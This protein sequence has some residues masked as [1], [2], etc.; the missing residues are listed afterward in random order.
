[1]TKH[2]IETYAAITEIERNERIFREKE[3]ADHK[4]AT[5]K[6]LAIAAID[7]LKQARDL[8]QYSNDQAQH[9]IAEDVGLLLTQLESLKF[10][11]TGRAPIAYSHSFDGKQWI[12]TEEFTSG[13]TVVGAFTNKADAQ[14]YIETISD[15][16]RR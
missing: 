9:D 2:R 11:R 12:V 4:K 14:N 1:M 7:A 10:A 8:L 3:E 6:Q 15:G 13:Y 5:D 16:G